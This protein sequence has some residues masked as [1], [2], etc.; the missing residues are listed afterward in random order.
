ML[1]DKSKLNKLSQK[2]ISLEL[3][4]LKNCF[5]SK[6]IVISDWIISWIKKDLEQGKIKETDLLPKKE[7]WAYLLGVSVGTIQNA[8]RIV[9]DKG[10]VESKQ[11][12]GTMIKNPKNVSNSIRKLTLYN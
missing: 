2:D 3:P 9:E 10:Y 5:E 4:D 11:K 1:I 6:T 12:I 7:E 8:L